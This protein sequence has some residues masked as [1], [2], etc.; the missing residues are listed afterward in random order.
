LADTSLSFFAGSSMRRSGEVVLSCRRLLAQTRLL[1][2]FA[3][4]CNE[5]AEAAL[6]DK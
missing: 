2:Q 1:P 3:R 4:T 6:S 5:L